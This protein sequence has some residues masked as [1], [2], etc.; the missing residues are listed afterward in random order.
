[1]QKGKNIQVTYSI[2]YTEI[3]LYEK[4]QAAWVNIQLNKKFSKLAVKWSREQAINPFLAI[5][6]F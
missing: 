3:Q 6:F 4:E 5:F 2:P 1:M